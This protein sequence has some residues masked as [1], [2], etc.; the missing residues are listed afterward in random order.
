MKISTRILA[1]FVALGVSAY[2]AGCNQEQKPAATEGAKVIQKVMHNPIRADFAP[3][4]SIKEGRK[5]IYVVIKTLNNS[6]WKEVVEGLKQASAAADVNVYMG[7]ALRDSDWE[8]QRAMLE[9]L[10]SKKIDAV[11]MA[12]TDSS[13][14]APAVKALKDKRIPVVIIDT[15]LYSKDYDAS[16]MTNNAAAG[17]KAAEEMLKLLQEAGAKENQELVVRIQQSSQ[18]SSAI[19]DRL[20]G[21]CSYWNQ[22]APKSWQ[23]DKA[24]LIDYGD[25]GMAQKNAELALRTAK[26][27]GIIALNNNP[28]VAAATAM[29]KANRKDV[30]LVGFDYAPATAALIKDAN[31]KAA[32]IVQ[33]QYKMGY[34]AVTTA[35]SLA[36]GTKVAL[37]NNDTGIQIVNAKNQAAFESSLKNKK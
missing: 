28:T 16:F 7:A 10:D 23:L 32:S 27:G 6:Y 15:D 8:T 36:A 9:E 35:A 29:Q 33:N 19:V 13:L 12:P 20:D 34:E 22:K 5:N 31:F 21:F 4:S 17:M 25:K 14:L 30:V 1:L 11:I 24:L 37:K 2:V 18:S 3:V 26:L